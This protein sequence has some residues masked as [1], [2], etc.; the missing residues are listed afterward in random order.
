M[1]GPSSHDQTVPG[2]KLRRDREGRRRTFSGIAGRFVRECEVQKG[3]QMFFNCLHHNSGAVAGQHAM[4]EAHGED[5]VGADGW[6]G[7]TPGTTSYKQP[8]FSFQK[9][10]LK[11]HFTTADM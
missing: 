8:S 6:I 5:L 1:N 3:Q 9:S 2:G 10:R 11:L 4:S 7:W